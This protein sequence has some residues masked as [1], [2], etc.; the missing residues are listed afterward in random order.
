MKTNRFMKKGD[1]K[2]TGFYA[3]TVVYSKACAVKLLDSM[4][5]FLV[6]YNALLRFVELQLALPG[7]NL[8]NDAESRYVKKRIFTRENKKEEIVEKWEFDLILDTHNEDEHYYL[9]QWK[10]HALIWQPAADLKG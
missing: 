8:I 4:R 5:I 7:Q 9:I 6:F 10:Y 2:W 3:V 1:N